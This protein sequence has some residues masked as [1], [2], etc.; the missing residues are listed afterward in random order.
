MAIIYPFGAEDLPGEVGKK[1]KEAVKKDYKESKLAVE[2]L[3]EEL[4]K[5]KLAKLIRKIRRRKK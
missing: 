3:A 1:L 5:S 2:V 4:R